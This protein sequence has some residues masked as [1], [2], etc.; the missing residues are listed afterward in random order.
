VSGH[1]PT[2]SE[3]SDPS[4]DPS[5]LA[6]AQA[7]REEQD[8]RRARRELTLATMLCLVG[9]GAV[10]LSVGRPW[11]TAVQPSTGTVPGVQVDLVGRDLAPL[12]AGLGLLALASAGALLALGRRLRPVLG[13][14]MSLSGLVMI[15]DTL[16]AAGRAATRVED[17]FAD[18]AV[19]ATSTAWPWLAVAG[20]IAVVFAGLVTAVRGGR[21]PPMS[22]RYD[23]PTPAAEPLSEP[24]ATMD[25]EAA[26]RALD[27]GE[28]PTLDAR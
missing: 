19:T 13:V 28:D 2:G 14:V 25:S 7:D 16:L 18:P 23:K 6:H 17:Q 8:R 22:R 11:S 4:A 9:A 26:W 24:G 1:E 27:R 3:P 15:V 12:T 21:W 20:G 10:L 5:D